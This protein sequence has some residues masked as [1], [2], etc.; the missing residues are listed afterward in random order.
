MAVS[1]GSQGLGLR[2]IESAAVAAV[3]IVRVLGVG[4]GRTLMSRTRRSR[5]SP[6]SP[7]VKGPVPPVAQ[8]GGPIDGRVAR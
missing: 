6:A 4:V 1:P 3:G 7:G 8:Y 5:L 2:R